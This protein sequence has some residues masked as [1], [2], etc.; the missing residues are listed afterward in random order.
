[1]KES[2]QIEFKSAFNEISDLNMQILQVSWDAYP[3]MNAAIND[4]DFGKVRKFINKVNEIGRFQ[5]SGSLEDDLRKLK[6]INKDKITNAALLLFAKEDVI[7]NTHLGRFKTPFTIIDDR[8]L[9]LPLFESVEET[10][11]YIRSQIKYAFEITG[12]TTQRTEI[13]EYPL[14]AIRELVLNA[15]IHRDYLSPA[16]VQIKIF[17]NYITFFNPGGLHHDLT[18]EDLKTDSYP[19]YARNKLLAEAFY[20]TGDTEKYGSGFFRIRNAL[21][22]YPSMTIDF[23]EISGG[24]LVTVAYEEQKISTGVTKIVTK[25]RK[26]VTEKVTE[27]QQHII[28][29]F[30]K[31]QHITAEELSGIIGISTRK[32]KENIQKL[33]A[34]GLI[35]RV[36]ADKGGYWKVN[37]NE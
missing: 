25:N 23:K 26:K 27:N 33:K 34:K 36:G 4:I 31:N 24:F 14:D 17:D 20:L 2:Q 18:I 21:A 15:A 13:P 12:Q 19:A 3:A 11:K 8:M 6:L 5:L 35:E 1:M 7:Y 9:R 30:L 37:K 32:I 22:E 29:E 16:D 28:N 10:M